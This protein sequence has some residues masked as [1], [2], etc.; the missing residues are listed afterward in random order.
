MLAKKCQNLHIYWSHKNC[1]SLISLVSG[2][3]FLKH[4]VQA[5]LKLAVVP[6]TR[7]SIITK[8]NLTQKKR[9]HK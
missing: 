4:V 1:L 7:S 6:F 3:K 9:A 2:I 8:L 5:L